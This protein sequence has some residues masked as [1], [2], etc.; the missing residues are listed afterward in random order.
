MSGTVYK[1]LK[2][3]SSSTKWNKNTHVIEKEV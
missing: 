3:H 2:S 1:S